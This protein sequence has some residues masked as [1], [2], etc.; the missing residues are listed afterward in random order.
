MST[1]S[2]IGRL[3]PDGTVDGI[4]CHWD[5]YPEH[6]GLMLTTH[7]A[8]PERVDSLIALGNLSLLGPEIGEKHDFNDIMNVK[9][10]RAYGR[11]RGDDA[12]HARHYKDV[13]E[14]MS[15]RFGVSYLYLYSQGRWQCFDFKGSEI[16]IKAQD[17]PG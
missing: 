5:G 15:E 2:M 7:Y 1:R 11:D 16:Q 10:C 14:F 12:Q 3:N 13:Y 4:Y 6:N 17:D 9:W 8:T